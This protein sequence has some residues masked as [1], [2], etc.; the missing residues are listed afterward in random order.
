VAWLAAM[1]A[2]PIRALNGNVPAIDSIMGALTRCADGVCRLN[3]AY[4]SLRRCCAA[5][6]KVLG[7]TLLCASVHR[8]GVG[9]VQRLCAFFG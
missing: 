6:P 2:A 4:D 7:N 9:C 8:L 3:G 5:R 1:A